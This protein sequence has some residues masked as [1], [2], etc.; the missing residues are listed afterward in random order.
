MAAFNKGTAAEKQHRR[1]S[2]RQQAPTFLSFIIFKTWLRLR[3][4]PRPWLPWIRRI[5]PEN[6]TCMAILVEGE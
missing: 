1:S 2:K 3:H 4:Q 6:S 5:T